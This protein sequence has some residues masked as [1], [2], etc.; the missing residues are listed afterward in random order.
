MNADLEPAASE[1]IDSSP[2]P[3]PLLVRD[4][5]HWQ[6]VIGMLSDVSQEYL[7]MWHE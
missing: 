5:P 7:E 1:S 2:A 6:G 3:A 4:D